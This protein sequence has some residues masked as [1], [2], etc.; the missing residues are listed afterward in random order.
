MKKSYRGKNKTTIRGTDNNEIFE[1]ICWTGLTVAIV[2][3][4]LLVVIQPKT[5]W[6]I[7]C[8][9]GFFNR[10]RAHASNGKVWVIAPNTFRFINSKT[11]QEVIVTGDCLVKAQRIEIYTGDK[12]SEEN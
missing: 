2:L 10:Y 8:D 11:E 5:Q 12:V 9:I 1:F 4:T 6:D 7:E 3:T